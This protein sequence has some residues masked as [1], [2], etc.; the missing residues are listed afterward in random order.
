MEVHPCNYFQWCGY[1]WG[2]WVSYVTTDEFLVRVTEMTSRIGVSWTHSPLLYFQPI[3]NLWIM[4]NY[5]K[6]VNQIT[7][8][9]SNS[10]N[11][12]FT[13]IRR[14]RSKNSPD[15]HA[16]CEA[17]LDNLIDSGNFYLRGYLPL[18]WNDSTTHIRGL[19][20]Y[21]KEGLPFAWDL[22]LE[23]SA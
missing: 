22:S 17:N 14:L 6:D 3:L 12:I 5:Q 23:N 15:M 20:V 2:P 19:A 9:H 10:L 8:D 4:A 16:L 7:L 1:F 13:N 11:L 18:I 21:V